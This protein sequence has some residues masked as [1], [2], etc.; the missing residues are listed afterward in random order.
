MAP[1]GLLR[2]L[3]DA[4]LPIL[5]RT[6]AEVEA[7]RS[8]YPGGAGR[9]CRRGRGAAGRTLGS[10]GDRH[11]AAVF[12][13]LSGT[14][15]PCTASEVWPDRLP[16]VGQ[17]RNPPAPLANLPAPGE[18]IRVGIVSGF[19][20]DHTIYRLFLEGWLAEIDRNR[21]EVSAFHTGRVSDAVTERCAATADR[22]I[23]GLNSP[24][25]WRASV[26]ATLPHVLLY[27][28][29]G[30]DPIA[31]RLAGQRL[32]PVQCVSWGH[33]QTSGL[34]TMDYFLSADLME[35][36]EAHH[37]TTAGN[38]CAC[39]PSACTT[40]PRRSTDSSPRS[41]EPGAGVPREVPIYWSGQAL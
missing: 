2:T 27:P 6:T 37:T 11:L 36:P 13:A 5:Y 31:A 23:C 38:W 40:R 25:A 15:R 4:Q 21:F 29:L 7:R 16:P 9:A 18:R 32:A 20:Q 22:F 33:P 34:P 41:R 26:S 3:H 10:R 19:F 17:R 14:Q 39:P 1:R 24:A 8:R 12:P 28:E 35:P 30:M